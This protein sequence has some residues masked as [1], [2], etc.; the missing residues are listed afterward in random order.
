MS[1]D[2]IANK[3]T[4][5]K[6]AKDQNCDQHHIDAFRGFHWRPLY[7]G[8]VNHFLFG[9]RVAAWDTARLIQDFRRRASLFFGSTH[10][11]P[12]IVRPPILIALAPARAS[13]A[14]WASLPTRNMK[15]PLPVPHSILPRTRKQTPPNMRFSVTPF[16]RTSAERSLTASFSFSSGA[17]FFHF[18]IRIV[19]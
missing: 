10:M 18:A 19:R 2:A 3:A 14:E 16:W 5:G 7:R 4:H 17:T 11:N 15:S 9:G 8:C 1:G 13:A 12:P 6:R